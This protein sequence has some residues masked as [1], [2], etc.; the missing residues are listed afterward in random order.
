MTEAPQIAGRVS[1]ALKEAK[2]DVLLV[3]NLVNIRYLTGFTGSNALLAVF[4]DRFV[5][6]TDPR[7]KLQ[8]ANLKPRVSAKPLLV[9]AAAYL[10]KRRARVAFERSNNCASISSKYSRSKLRADPGHWCCGT[11]ARGQV[12]R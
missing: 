4:P 3:T 7:Y 1:E 12:A 11:P 8:A 10:S 2:A 5:F 9:S 6:W